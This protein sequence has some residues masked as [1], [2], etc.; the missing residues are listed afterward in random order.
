MLE[1][2]NL[3]TTEIEENKRYFVF[4]SEWLEV[5]NP[6]CFNFVCYVVEKSRS[7]IKTLSEE[8]DNIKH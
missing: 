7:R 1:I 4:L 2:T 8:K 6:S 5:T 3:P